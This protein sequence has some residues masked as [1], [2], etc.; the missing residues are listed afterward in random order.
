MQEC[1]NIVVVEVFVDYSVDAHQVFND[2]VSHWESTIDVLISILIVSHFKCKIALSI[3][4]I[5]CRLIIFVQNTKSMILPIE[6]C[7]SVILMFSFIEIFV[8]VE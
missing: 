6:T 4:A 3:Y 5:C 1:I 2:A 8:T 7:K